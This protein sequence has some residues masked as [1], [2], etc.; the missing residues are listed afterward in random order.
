MKLSCR[1]KGA[2][3]RV[4]GVS[5]VGEIKYD[6]W[7]GGLE[8]DC[9][10]G[11]VDKC[12][13]AI[14][15]YA[16]PWERR[17]GGRRERESITHT[18]NKLN[19]T[20]E[21]FNG[22]Y[23]SFVS[24]PNLTF[25]DS[26]IRV[27]FGSHPLLYSVEKL[28]A[29]DSLELLWNPIS[30]PC[31]KSNIASLVVVAFMTTLKHSNQSGDTVC[32][33]QASTVTLPFPRLPRGGPCVIRISISSG[34][35]FHLSSRDWPRGK[36][37]PHPLNHGVLREDKKRLVHFINVKIFATHASVPFSQGRVDNI[38]IAVFPF[39]F[40]NKKKKSQNASEC[41]S[42]GWGPGTTRAIHFSLCQGVWRFTAE[43][44]SS[45][46]EADW[47]SCQHQWAEAC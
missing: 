35:W 24:R 38:Q 18:V 1:K 15:H 36:L 20:G 10:C 45:V 9:T 12:C 16:I 28:H 34:I 6:W 37:K 11:G 23:F 43:Q 19:C 26:S 39:F 29:P 44:R 3:F 7:I 8:T 40:L 41:R 4:S 13:V 22:E 47:S 21:V 5:W 32:H 25:M 17:R 46:E 33:I 27:K 42:I 31:A 2:G 14:C 30:E